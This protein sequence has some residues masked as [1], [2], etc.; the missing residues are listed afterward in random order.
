[1]MLGRVG[2]APPAGGPAQPW[3]GHSDLLKTFHWLVRNLCL[4]SHSLCHPSPELG[5]ARM[6]VNMSGIRLRRK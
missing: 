2:P 5:G 6:A 1:M 3:V 4:C